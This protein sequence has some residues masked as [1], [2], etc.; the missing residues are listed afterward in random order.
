MVIAIISLPCNSYVRIKNATYLNK[1]IF[2]VDFEIQN[3]FIHIGLSQAFIHIC[4]HNCKGVLPAPVN[5]VLVSSQQ[6]GQM[7]SDESLVAAGGKR[8]RTVDCGTPYKRPM[9]SSGR[10][11]VEMMKR[12]AITLFAN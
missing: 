6:G 11:L 5:A 4:K 10:Q 2:D 7:T 1:D 3:F 9:S 12:M 8:L